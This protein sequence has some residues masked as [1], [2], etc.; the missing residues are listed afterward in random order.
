M[1]TQRPDDNKRDHG[2]RWEFP[3]GKL[4]FGESP[5]ESL[6]REIFEEM[7]IRVKVEDLVEISSNV[8]RDDLHVVLVA[9]R[10]IYLGG[11]IQKKDIS[12]FKWLSVEEMDDYD[13]TEADQVFVKKLK[14]YSYFP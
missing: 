10:C 5:R 6:E 9:F 8:Y 14:H 3:G 11:T 1:I 12:D 13:I 2:G 4:Q 7:G